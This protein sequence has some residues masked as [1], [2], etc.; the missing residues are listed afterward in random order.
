LLFNIIA[1][2]NSFE[3][4]Q[5]FCDFTL[6]FLI[7]FFHKK[8]IEFLAFKHNMRIEEPADQDKKPV[9]CV[10][11]LNNQFLFCSYEDSSASFW[12]IGSLNIG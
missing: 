2:W 10:K 3:F 6:I 1:F 7:S 8:G 11:K 12:H 9:V 5:V 4:S